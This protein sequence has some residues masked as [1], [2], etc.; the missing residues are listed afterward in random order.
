MDRK[1]RLVMTPGNP[2]EL[3]PIGR[4]FLETLK[5]GTAKALSPGVD[6]V[7]LDFDLGAS[8]FQLLLGG[9]GVGL[10]RFLDGLRAP[11]TRS[12][13]SFR[14]R[15]VSSRTALMTLTLFARLQQ[16]NGE[17][18]LLFSSSGASATSGQGGHGTAAAKPTRQTFLPFP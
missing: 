13:A 17:L 10:R 12:L 3:D 7:L 2:A 5:P 16:H 6:I 9:F 15:P 11:S 14:P 18:G 1:P 4:G 8:F